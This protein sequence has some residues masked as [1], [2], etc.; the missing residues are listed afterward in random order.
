MGG[1][2]VDFIGIGAERS[3]TT[4]IADVL[5]EHHE[6]CFSKIKEVTFF[7]EFDPHLL[8]VRNLKYQRGVSW[9]E[10][11]FDHCAKDS[12]KGEY[13]PTYLYSRKTAERILKHFPN[14]KTVVSL[15]DPVTRALSQYLHDKSIGLIGNI[16]FEE[17]LKKHDSYFEK[18]RYYK[19]LSYY[20][21]LFPRKNVLVILHEDIKKNPERTV[22]ALYKF[23]NL[24]DL[25]YK[26][27]ILHKKVNVATESKTPFINSLLLHSEYFIKRNRMKKLFALLEKTG[28]R[29]FASKLCNEINCQPLTEYPKMNN[30]TKV[31]LKKIFREDIEK[32]ENLID[33]DLQSWK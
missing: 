6:V 33:R 31:Y 24:N 8:K 11:H 16:S 13:S 25:G 1:F 19:Y 29:K 5:K 4:W 3:A 32:L 18:G 22:R 9:Y 26:P 28:V 12:V 10:K 20:F 27:Q 15:R 2:I 7:N 14:V 23:L 30:D 21:E 17:A